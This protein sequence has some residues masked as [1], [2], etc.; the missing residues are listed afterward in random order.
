[1]GNP[2]IYYAFPGYAGY[3]PLGIFQGADLPPANFDQI[4]KNGFET[5]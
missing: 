5:A 4:F 1:M 2:N 3:T